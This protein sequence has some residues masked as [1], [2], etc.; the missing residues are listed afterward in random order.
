MLVKEIML[1]EINCFIHEALYGYPF[2]EHIGMF[3]LIGRVIA[4]CDA[5]SRVA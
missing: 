4:Q 1:S 3:R 5:Q 2:D